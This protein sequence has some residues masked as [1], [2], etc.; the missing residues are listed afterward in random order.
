M[1]CGLRIISSGAKHTNPGYSGEDMECH[2]G[3]Q[4]VR[5]G[6]CWKHYRQMLRHEKWLR[7]IENL[8]FKNEIML[9]VT[10]IEKMVWTGILGSREET[11]RYDGILKQITGSEGTVWY[12]RSK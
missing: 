8:P 12:G 2:C 10:G 9:I 7:S 1:G 3:K 5:R 11:T 6:L 4:S